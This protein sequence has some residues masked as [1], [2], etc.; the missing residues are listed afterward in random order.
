MAGL[1]NAY[2]FYGFRAFSHERAV[3]ED[4]FSVA[5]LL[6][7]LRA[8]EIVI[9]VDLGLSEGEAKVWTCDL[10]KD[11]VAINGDCRSRNSRSLPPPPR[12]TGMAAC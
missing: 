12:S 5:P 3:L 6:H 8:A 11:Y 1:G 10:T 4:K 2:G 7:P 9:R